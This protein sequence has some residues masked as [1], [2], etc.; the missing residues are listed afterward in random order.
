MSMD[1]MDGGPADTLLL[2]AAGLMKITS[3]MDA[4]TETGPTCVSS[5][6]IARTDQYLSKHLR[7]N[8]VR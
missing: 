5:R 2:A 4:Q 1:L 6:C 8:V 3:T 7:V